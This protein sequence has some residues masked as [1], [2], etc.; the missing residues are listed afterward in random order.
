MPLQVIETRFFKRQN[1]LEAQ[2]LLLNYSHWS[3]NGSQTSIW[4][5]TSEEL[6]S[7]VLETL[8]GQHLLPG[9]LKWDREKVQL[10]SIGEVFGFL[11][12]LLM[13]SSRSEIMVFPRFG[14]RDKPSSG[15][16]FRLHM[17]LIIDVSSVGS[18]HIWYKWMLFGQVF[19][20]FGQVFI[21]F[22]QVS[23]CFRQVSVCYGQSSDTRWAVEHFPSL[24]ALETKLRK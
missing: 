20:C 19:V 2:F 24:K 3:L 17:L 9:D 5:L 8:Y 11:P 22:G 4:T 6:T 23:V 16:F 1:G 15:R 14:L 10:L 21:C 18:M 13:K 12:T 7:K